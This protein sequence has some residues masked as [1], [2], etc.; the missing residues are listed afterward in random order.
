MSLQVSG[1]ST[2]DVFRDG[3][4]FPEMVV[5]PA[6]AFLMGSPPDEL[7]RGPDDTEDPQHRVRLAAPFAIGRFAVTVAEFEAFV[8]ATGQPVHDRLFTARDQ[9][10]AWIEQAGHSF[11]NPGF[12]QTGL[13]P[14]VGI[15][16]ADATAYA[17]WLARQTGRHYHLP[18][19]AQW[20]Y[21][22]RAG[23]TTPFWWG[24]TITPDQANYDG[25]HLY[26]GGVPGIAR[27]GTVPVETFMPNP[28]GLFQVHGNVW[29]WCADCWYP[30]HAGAP[31]DGAAR[32]DGDP[33]VGVL[34]GGS[35]LNGPWVLRSA[36]RIG[37]PRSFRHNSF[38][39]RVACTL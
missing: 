20:E 1:L 37:D 2:G 4:G 7:L 16:F 25:R 12:P 30:S 28:F 10:D 39:L 27:R 17:A 23:T 5:V 18:T 13:H 33:T 21:A 38:G 6:G 3:E 11:R 26:A 29:E 24:A 34:R 22:A 31:S 9:D 35:W 19:E 15:T 14:V 36:K 8:T 32:L